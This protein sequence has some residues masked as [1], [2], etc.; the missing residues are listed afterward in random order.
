MVRNVIMSQ[1]WNARNRQKLVIT[2]LLNSVA[3]N[4]SL[5]EV[6]IVAYPSE[7]G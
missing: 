6:G 2:E 1:I 4:F 3:V 5:E 7:E